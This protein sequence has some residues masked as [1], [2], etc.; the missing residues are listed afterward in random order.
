M[1]QWNFRNAGGAESQNALR[2]GAYALAISAVVLAILVAVNL[3]VSVLP[4]RLTKYDISASKL[5]SITS[6]TK[7]VAGALEQDVTIYWVVQ[8]G[9][10]DEVLENLLSKYDSLS[11]HINVVKKNPDVYPTFT[12]Q[13]TD[14][15]VQN[16]SLIVECGQRSRYIALDDI[17]L[18]DVDLYTGRYST[19]DFDG[20]GAITSAIDYVVREELPQL[21]LLEGHGEAELPDSFREQ[22]E[23]ENIE[24]N[25][26]SLLTVDEIPE[27]A[28]CVMIYA[29]KSDL[30][31][32]E[33]NL[34]A[35]YTKN[36]GKLLAA[37]GPVEEGN[38]ET[39][40]SLLSD[41]GIEAAEGI[42]VEADR[43]HYT[44]Q[45]PPAL[46]PAMH[47]H[48][49]TQPLMDENYYPVMPIAVGLTLTGSEEAVTELLTSS[50]AAFSKRAG[51][52]L[53]TYEREDGDVSGPFALAVSI[54]TPG[55]GSIVWFTS[56]LFLEDVWNAA[57]SG[58]NSN[59]GMNA[60]SSLIGETE[61]M[62]IR[63]KSLDYNYLT[64]SDSTASLLK[65]VM[66]GTFP[67]LYL[68]A[69]IWVVMRRRRLQNEPV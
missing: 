26:L 69:G 38:L 33:R 18:G 68:L 40:Y 50:D 16:N 55:G 12:Q 60:L 11:D 30:S 5:Y 2:G 61:A 54:E 44:F 25:T 6:N 39:L 29:P 58:A 59:L 46:L 8:A 4:A 34:L 35:D 45:G 63:S 15:T 48:A 57:S 67:L 22:I 62:A 52:Q 21:Y 19:T 14:E 13:Y 9:E 65:A 10:E 56:S 27:D 37:A 20:E 1:K 24:I 43:E 47:S 41:Y 49:V 51:Y 3:L 32:E 31:E 64:I 53:T 23:K 36:G 7:V 66:I 42:V 17:Y 28:D